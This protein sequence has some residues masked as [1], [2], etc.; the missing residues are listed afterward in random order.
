K[1]VNASSEGIE[2]RPLM[3]PDLPQTAEQMRD[4]RQAVLNNPLVYGLFVDRDLSSALIQVDFYDHLVDYSTIFPQIQ[5]LLDASPVD[6]KVSLNLVGVSILY[7]WVSYYLDETVSIAVLSLV[8]MLLL[9][10]VFART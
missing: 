1:R 5:G 10:F 6:D 3:W 2:T 8:A 9:L 4:L 7:G